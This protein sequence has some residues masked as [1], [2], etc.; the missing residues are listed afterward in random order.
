MNG[1][2]P[3][4]TAI[5]TL[6]ELGLL[7]PTGATMKT[8]LAIALLLST[9]ALTACA[10]DEADDQ[11]DDNV[12]VAPVVVAPVKV[13]PQAVCP[14]GCGTPRPPKNPCGPRGCDGS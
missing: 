2:V 8:I 4:M 9:A 3:H 7:Q 5:S 12:V 11:T 13:E 6:L 10:G 14:Q 1:A